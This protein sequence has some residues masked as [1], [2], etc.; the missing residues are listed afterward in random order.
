MAYSN[1]MDDIYKNAKAWKPNKKQK[2]FIVFDDMIADM[3]SNKKRQYL[4]ESFIWDRTLNFLLLFL[5]QNLFY[6][7]KKYLTKFHT[8]F[9]HELHRVKFNPSSYTEPS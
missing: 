7:T 6:Y 8:L 9:Y 5:L 2:I 4:I 1:N 3:L